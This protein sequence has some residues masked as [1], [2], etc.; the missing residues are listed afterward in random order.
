MVE[1]RLTLLDS[2]LHNQVDAIEYKR[3][4]PV[5]EIIL[6]V[7][8]VVTYF[9]SRL[10]VNPLGK[11]LNEG[12]KSGKGFLLFTKQKLDDGTNTKA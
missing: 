10:P 5:L 9:H 7:A 4:H 8:G 2:L 11:E 1:I 6:Q 12:H 3:A